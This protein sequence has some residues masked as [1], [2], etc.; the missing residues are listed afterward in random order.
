MGAQGRDIA[1]RAMH[2]Q[3]KLFYAKYTRRKFPRSG[4]RFSI[5]DIVKSW[6]WNDYVK[7]RSRAE[8]KPS[9]LHLCGESARSWQTM[10]SF[11]LPN[12]PML[13]Y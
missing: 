13:R 1:E 8:V 3:A 2:R 11:V 7:N 9:A 5:D 4:R 6:R 12:F 10:G